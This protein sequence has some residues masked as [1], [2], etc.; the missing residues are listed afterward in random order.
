M[1][2]LNNHYITIPLQSDSLR[3]A[4]Y[5]SAIISGG[6][7]NER[8][9]DN[10]FSLQTHVSA[11]NT[12]KN[13]QA[14]YG[15]GIALGDYKLNGYSDGNR[16]LVN[17]QIINQYTG[18]KFFGAVGFN[19]GMNAVIPFSHGGEWRIIGIETSL[20][21]EFGDYLAVRKQ[22]P[23]SAASFINRKSFFGTLGGYTELVGKTNY[24]SFSMKINTGAVLGKSYHDV[25]SIGNYWYFSFTLAATIK[26]WT[27]Y[28]QANFAPKAS[29]ALFG[30]NYSL[31]R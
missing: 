8:G 31:G 21:K 3:S 14:Y 11:A 4:Y 9:H 15:A 30:A 22:L 28:I 19:G 18:N 7:A 5:V 23:D 1:N 12:F 16:S 26:K 25:T 2:G 13:F 20:C 27:P 17:A 6:S 29:H 10:C 24:G